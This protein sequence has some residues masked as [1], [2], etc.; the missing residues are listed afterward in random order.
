MSLPERAW[1]KPFPSYWKSISPH[2]LIL[3]SLQEHSPL[4]SPSLILMAWKNPCLSCGACCAAYSFAIYWDSASEDAAS[5]IT[6][7]SDPF[8]GFLL[9][10]VADVPP[11]AYLEGTVGESV[12]CSIYEK[13]PDICRRFIPAWS[14]G[15]PNEA[16]D[17]S[18]ERFGLPPLGPGDWRHLRL[19]SNNGCSDSTAP[20]KNK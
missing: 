16:C 11:C 15:A 4:P 7:S 3:A 19:L 6:P 5:M 10:G 9:Q 12:Y 20:C 18:R 14:E 13:R 8:Q 2:S 17:R 1:S